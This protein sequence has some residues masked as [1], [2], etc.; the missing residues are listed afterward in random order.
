MIGRRAVF[1][2]ANYTTPIIRFGSALGG[3][4]IDP[5]TDGRRD[6]RPDVQENMPQLGDLLQDF[7]FAQPARPPSV[8]PEHPA[9]GQAP[10]GG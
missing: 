8:L 6:P 5:Q 1:S 2:C 10:A 9:P 3:Q 4:R 7:D